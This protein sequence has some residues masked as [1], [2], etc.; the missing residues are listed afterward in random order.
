M[1]L[2]ERLDAARTEQT[3]HQTVL[4]ALLLDY[5]GTFS[6][7]QLQNILWLI[8]SYRGLADALQGALDAD[9]KQLLNDDAKTKLLAEILPLA[10][11]LHD[12][13]GVKVV[14]NITTLI[15]RQQIDLL[16]VA[17]LT[18][19]CCQ[20]QVVASQHVAVERATPQP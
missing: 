16:D 14:E 12:K 3:T 20:L 17:D 2:I 4:D 10:D 7:D 18:S 1:S 13:T 11:W 19:L 5:P 6:S 9:T 8:R 15:P